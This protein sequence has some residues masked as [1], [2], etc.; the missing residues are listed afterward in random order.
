MKTICRVMAFWFLC[1]V[2]AAH[3]GV[4]KS[5]AA[6][7]SIATM[8][9]AEEEEAFKNLFIGLTEDSLPEV[10]VLP[11]CITNIGRNYWLMST[12][13]RDLTISGSSITCPNSAFFFGSPNLMHL[14]LPNVVA[15]N[16]WI[17]NSANDGAAIYCPKCR[18]F[19]NSRYI[20]FNGT[21]TRKLDVYIDEIPCEEIKAIPNFPGCDTLGLPHLTFHGSDG[22]LTWNGSEW[23]FT[24]E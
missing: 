7:R 10:V 3:G 9:P 13:C 4:V 23:V 22:K 2:V 19:G 8:S 21:S 12:K 5:A 1:V 17:A 24:A 18:R 15:I 6:A 16:S 14:R 11:S 20:F